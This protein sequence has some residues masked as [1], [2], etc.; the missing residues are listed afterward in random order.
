MPN[1]CAALKAKVADIQSTLA[2]LKADEVG[3]TGSL[4]HGIAGQI[5]S[6]QHELT[7]AKAKLFAC[8]GAVTKT[9]P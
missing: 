8:E 1:E 2:D 5:L 4:L 6:K 3:A 7:E 9:T